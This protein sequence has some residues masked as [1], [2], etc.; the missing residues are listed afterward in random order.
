MHRYALALVLSS[1]AVSAQG[2]GGRPAPAAQA[3]APEAAPAAEWQSQFTWRSLGPASMG[4]RIT[5]IAVQESDPSTFWVATAT[6]GLLKT[7]NNGMTFE[8]Q[9]DHEGAS[10]VGAVAVAASDPKIVWVG[11]GENN[12]RNSS[13]YGDG[14]YK[15]VDGGKTWK[16]MGL[17]ASFQTGDIL[18]HPTDP[19]TVYVGA[20]G[21]LWGPS[22]ER[23]L[24]KTTDGGA[25]WDRVLFVDDKTGVID[26]AMHPTD[27]NTLLVATYER[28][29]DGFDTNDPS[30]KWG[31]G[32]GMHRTTDG[33]KTFTKVTQ[34]LPSGMYGRIGFDWY[35]ADPNV[36]Y[37]IVESD[38]IGK[39]GEGVG[40]SGL[41]GEDA[42]T[43]ARLTQVTDGGPAAKAGLATGDIVLSVD[44]HTVLNFRQ[45][46]ER[47]A[48]RAAGEIVKLE[49]ARE[50]ESKKLEL[51]LTGVRPEVAGLQEM[52]ARAARARRAPPRSRRP[53]APPVAAAAASE[54]APAPIARTSP[55]S[56]ASAPTSRACR[57]RPGT[58]TAASTV[59]P[60][61]ACRGRAST[62]STR[63]RCTSAR[64]ASIRRTRPTSGCSA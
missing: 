52:A 34:G 62:A 17:R 2:R 35:R 7:T 55:A 24:Y 60:T 41:R 16:H 33:G 30:K 40:F 12:P 10:S 46:E 50:G 31:A 26:L 47:L 58:N 21:R 57:A 4:G 5:A 63:G 49:I 6:A 56:A 53:V 20:L 1:L 32:S 3:T 9:F 43:G 29:R 15:S 14:V 37:A 13:S 48:Q 22:E 38:A 36:V 51:A 23:G 61:P 59:P 25:S 44:G 42:E 39:Q 45:L 18:I 64:C 27:P 54:A 8:H 28:E 19:N 11:T